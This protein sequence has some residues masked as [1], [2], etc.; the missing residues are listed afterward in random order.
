M[1]K[2]AQS[3]VNKSV[4]V[5]ATIIKPTAKAS[6][7]INLINPGISARNPDIPPATITDNN[8]PKAIKAPPKIAK[9]ANFEKDKEVF[10]KLEFIKAITASL[11]VLLIFIFFNLFGK[12]IFYLE[13]DFYLLPKISISQK[14]RS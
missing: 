4:F 14:T 6:P 1:V 12:Y 3:L 13:L 11:G 7:A 2:A 5:K 8:P 9:T 10:E